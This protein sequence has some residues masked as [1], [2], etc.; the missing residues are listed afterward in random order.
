MKIFEKKG[1]TRLQCVGHTSQRTWAVIR[2]EDVVNSVR[3]KHEVAPL[4]RMVRRC[5]MGA[6]TYSRHSR[7]RSILSP[8]VSGQG[9]R[10]DCRLS[11]P[12]KCQGSHF[13]DLY[14]Q[15]FP[16]KWVGQRCVHIV[17]LTADEFGHFGSKQLVI[18][19]K[20]VSSGV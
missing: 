17:F 1:K 18:S 6:P 3:R 15:G 5:P 8:P 20:V 2:S 12:G 9:A 13:N 10:L 7:R 19:H 14:S 4:L 16:P 11:Y